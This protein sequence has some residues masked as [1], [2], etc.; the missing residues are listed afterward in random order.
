[1][2]KLKLLRRLL[3]VSEK[4]ITNS[5]EEYVFEGYVKKPLMGQLMDLI[6]STEEYSDVEKS[7][8]HYVFVMDIIIRKAFRLSKGFWHLCNQGYGDA[9]AGAVRTLLELCIDVE[10]IKQDKENRVERFCEH[11]YVA[12][13]FSMDLHTHRGDSIPGEIRNKIINEYETVKNKYPDFKDCLWS[14]KKPEQMAK[15]VE[16]SKVCFKGIYGTLSTYVHSYFHTMDAKSEYKSDHINIIP[17]QLTPS[18]ELSNLVIANTTVF[19]KHLM[20]EWLNATGVPITTELQ[21]VFDDIKNT[22]YQGNNKL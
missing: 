20:E 18:V 7:I 4:I 16:I 9:G 1:M 8:F 11:W 21:R 14:G 15:D 2:D 22:Y 3:D 17:T 5:F 6:D 19:F 10:Y 13:K 12:R